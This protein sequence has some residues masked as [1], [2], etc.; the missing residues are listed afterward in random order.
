MNANKVHTVFCEVCEFKHKP[1]PNPTFVESFLRDTIG[2]QGHINDSD[3]LCFRCYKY[4]NSLLKSDICIL[5][6]EKILAE[7]EAK[8]IQFNEAIKEFSPSDGESHVQLALRRTA[9]QVCNIIKLDQ[10]FLFPDVYKVFLQFLPCGID[11]TV[12]STKSRLLAFWGNEFGEVLFI[13]LQQK[14]WNC[15]S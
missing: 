3:L 4:F 10:D 5:S 8:E 13:L 11:H 14:N 7:L 12:S 2:L 6:N 9:L 15:I 1:C